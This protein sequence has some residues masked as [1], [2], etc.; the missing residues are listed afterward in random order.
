MGS[1]E[2]IMRNV[3][4]FEVARALKKKSFWYATIALPAFILVIFG[5]DYASNHQAQSRS[6]QQVQNY[7]QN[8]TFGVLDETGLINAKALMKQGHYVLESNQQSGINAVQNGT[9]TAFFYYPKHV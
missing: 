4:I 7:T 6:Q 3:I 8:S 9:I 5:I 2:R 1:K